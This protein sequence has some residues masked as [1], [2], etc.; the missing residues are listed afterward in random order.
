MNGATAARAKAAAT[1]LRLA[2][3]ERQL[4]EQRSLIQDL[5]NSAIHRWRVGF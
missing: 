1:A 4:A 3:V 2:R 5:H